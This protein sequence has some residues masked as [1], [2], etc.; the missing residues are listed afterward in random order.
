MPKSFDIV[1]T[2]LDFSKKVVP[3][4]DETNNISLMEN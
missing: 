1:A 4:R 2:K 3:L